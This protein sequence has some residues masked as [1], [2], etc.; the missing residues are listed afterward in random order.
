MDRRERYGSL[1][2]S[3]LLTVSCGRPPLASAPDAAPK[4][5]KQIGPMVR[6]TAFTLSTTLSL[7]QAATFARL[8]RLQTQALAAL[9]ARST[10]RTRVFAAD[11]RL[12]IVPPQS[13]PAAGLRLLFDGAADR[14][15]VRL[16]EGRIVRLPAAALVDVLDRALPSRRGLGEDPMHGALPR[17]QVEALTTTPTLRERW[18]VDTPLRYQRR[19]LGT[20]WSLKLGVVLEARSHAPE[21]DGH[22]S[23]LCPLIFK[24]A[25]GAD[26]VLAG[27]RLCPVEALGWRLELDN[28]DRESVASPRFET[29]VEAHG[30]GSVDKKL[31]HLDGRV[32]RAW[33]LPGPDKS[34]AQTI[35]PKQLKGLRAP[36]PH[37]AL[38]VDNR[39][40][41]AALIYLDG[42]LLGW[43]ASGRQM[44]FT[45][46]PHGFFRV[47]ATAPSGVRAWGPKELYLP[48]M[49]T[50]D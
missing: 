50:L 28:S 9:V 45:G 18:R 43:V 17:L 10:L 27:V 5:T 41:V 25:L 3:L 46:L 6:A 12:L 4:E 1:L 2:F 48:G 23:P 24:L 31:G 44:R 40:G 11:G 7:P 13:H 39:S 30:W 32:Q 42:A 35:P 19:D 33:R 21:M 29:R 34:G 26:D 47:F 49:L 38:A 20:L 8:N 16:P 36:G 15:D 37:G 22:I 14:L